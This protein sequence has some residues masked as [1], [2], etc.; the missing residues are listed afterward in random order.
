ML[1]IRWLYINL[2]F[3]HSF[4]VVCDLNFLCIRVMR[5]RREGGKCSG[6]KGTHYIVPSLPTPM[7]LLIH[8][9]TKTWLDMH[10]GMTRWRDEAHQAVLQQCFLVKNNVKEFNSVDGNT[11]AARRERLR[12][13]IVDWVV[14]DNVQNWEKDYWR[15][16]F[17]DHVSQFHMSVRHS[18][19]LC[20]FMCEGR[21]Y[22]GVHLL[23]CMSYCD[24]LSKCV[25]SRW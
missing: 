21:T 19:D 18:H 23:P 9:S 3:T 2:S 22:V 16:G 1:W 24:N 14:L 12:I 11:Y 6:S 4:I 8:P 17:L 10:S 20:I 5:L 25:L 15:C 7:T 13:L